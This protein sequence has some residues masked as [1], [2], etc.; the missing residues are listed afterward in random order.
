MNKVN[1]LAESKPFILNIDGSPCEVTAVVA[2]CGKREDAGELGVGI[3][4]KNEYGESRTFF[5]GLVVPQDPI[6]SFKAMKLLEQIKDYKN[7]TLCYCWYAASKSVHPSDI[8]KV[9]VIKKLIGIEKYQE[10]L[11]TPMTADEIDALILKLHQ[12]TNFE[13][14]SNEVNFK[15]QQDGLFF[16]ITPI[17][18]RY[19]TGE[20]VTLE[21]GETESIKPSFDKVMEFNNLILPL[22]R[23]GFTDGNFPLSRMMKFLGLTYEDFIKLKNPA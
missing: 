21:S 12:Y 6:Q 22:V 15:A 11:D 5:W 20:L 19:L 3:R 14:V 2:H 13:F 10:I 17:V 23:Q 1:I 4:L 8:E 18:G 7:S 16:P 9:E